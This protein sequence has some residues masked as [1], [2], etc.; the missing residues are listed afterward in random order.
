VSYTT[1]LGGDA[2]FVSRLASCT[3][4]ITIKSHSR[5]SSTQRAS[6]MKNVPARRTRRVC[7]CTSSR[8]FRD[9]T[10][11]FISSAYGILSHQSGSSEEEASQRRLQPRHKTYKGGVVRWLSFGYRWREYSQFR[12][13][14]LRASSALD[15]VRGDP[16]RTQDAASPRPLV[17]DHAQ[18]VYDLFLENPRIYS[19][20]S[21]IIP[22]CGQCGMVVGFQELLCF[23]RLWGRLEFAFSYHL[24]LTGSALVKCSPAN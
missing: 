23:V 2:R 5:T 13:S 20:S 22:G 7:A 6:Q 15:V 24:G 21:A 12:T 19:S 9:L 4:A 11:R 1:W 18:R 14:S 17:T 16:L 8:H 10:S 3:R